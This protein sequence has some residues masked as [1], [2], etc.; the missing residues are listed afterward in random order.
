MPSQHARKRSHLL[1][2][3]AAALIT[4]SL[5]AYGQGGPQVRLPDVVGLTPDVA[6]QDAYTKLKAYDKTA[7]IS[8]AQMPPEGLGPQPVAYALSLAQNGTSSNEIIEEDL[9]LPPHPQRVWRIVRTVRF[10]PGQ[11]PLVKNLLSDLR[12]KYGPESFANAGAI[13]NL[14]WYFDEQGQ[15]AAQG[16]GL[17]FSNCSGFSPPPTINPSVLQQGLSPLQIKLVQPVGALNVTLEPC[18]K[19]IAVNATMELA[20]DREIAALLLLSV[21]DYPLEVR[22]HRVTVDFL[23]NAAN[24]QHQQQLNNANQAP[25]TKL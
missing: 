18:R 20:A 9:T 21:E 13:P 16:G 19:L 3:I 1:G 25:K 6:M 11:Q 4:A 2:P 5:C 12:Q 24:A 8:I 23:S 15:H 17:T 14:H 7:R 10:P 22:E